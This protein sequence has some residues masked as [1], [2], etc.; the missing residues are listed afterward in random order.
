MGI[1]FTRKL[2]A[3]ALVATAAF[4]IVVRFFLDVMI[5]TTPKDA[6]ANAMV[7]I[8]LARRF[9]SYWLAGGLL[10]VA[11]LI[12]AWPFIESIIL[13]ESESAKLGVKF[14][15]DLH[16]NQRV[17][18]LQGVISNEGK[19]T[20]RGVK[21]KIIN[22]KDFTTATLKDFDVPWSYSRLGQID[23]KS[24]DSAVF[25]IGAMSAEGYPPNLELLLYAGDRKIEH[26]NRFRGTHQF[27][28]RILADG[29]GP[30]TKKIEVTVSEGPY[31][32][33]LSVA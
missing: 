16:R 3:I 26:Q 28:V 17:F 9:S 20:V 27:E 21:V 13:P 15:V 1:K 30:I 29:M 18:Y 7:W 11:V 5:Q 6:A 32:N 22:F 12:L 23:I 19:D 31:K 4:D 10:L 8:S 24:G 33:E 14:Q 25:D 2:A